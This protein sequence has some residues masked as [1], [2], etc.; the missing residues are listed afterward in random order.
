MGS[1]VA[2]HLRPQSGAY[3]LFIGAIANWHLG[4]RLFSNRHFGKRRAEAKAKRDLDDLA[5]R[6]EEISEQTR[7]ELRA[8]RSEIS[9][10]HQIDDALATERDETRWLN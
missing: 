3:R 6:F 2:F 9:S 10:A 5:E 1:F 8:L 4:S 7:A